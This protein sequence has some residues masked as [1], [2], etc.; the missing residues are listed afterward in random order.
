M[1]ISMTY[2][3]PQ[4]N[5]Q[6][7]R[8]RYALLM[9]LGLLVLAL[10]LAVS[11]GPVMSDWRLLLV[12]W[13]PGEL[14]GIEPIHRAVVAEIR[15]PRL[16]LGL[17]VGMVLAQA[18]TTMQTLCRNPLADPGLIGISAGAALC[19]LFVIAFGSQLGLVGDIWVT[20]GAFVGALGAT[21]LVYRLAGGLRGMNIATLIL[22][23]VALNALA[24]A[25][26]GLF[27]FY[28]DDEA[29]RLMSFWQM[30]SLAGV[31]WDN[32]PFGLL[33]MGI[34]SVAFWWRRHAINALLLGERQ[35]GYLGISVV[36]FKRELVIW[37]ALGVGGAVALT[38]MIGFIGLVIPHI[39]RLLVGASIIRVMPLS[40][41]L[42]ASVLVLAD[43]LARMLVAPAE[44]P[45][46]IITALLGAPFF[47][48]LLLK[49]KRR[50]HA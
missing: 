6:Q 31:T 30:G 17:A 49:F 50:L 13:W 5:T 29:L 28:A 33:A 20:L 42:G 45:I 44:L 10:V 15:L 46:G 2:N 47:I 4:A 34:A 22:A 48:V 39:A 36:S 21:F 16:V 40:M 9:T 7:R 3:P 35:A 23:G 26:I 8:Y 43:W 11:S 12:S 38:G 1:P 37:V 32:L 19:A 24:G 27:S 25:L 41:L 14:N 18:G